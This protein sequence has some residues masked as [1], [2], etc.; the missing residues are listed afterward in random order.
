M[1][2]PPTTWTARGALTRAD[3]A[4][5]PHMMSAAPGRTPVSSWFGWEERSGSA[6]PMLIEG[7][8]MRAFSPAGCPLLA[9]AASEVDGVGIGL[10]AVAGEC[11]GVGGRC[12]GRPNVQRRS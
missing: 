8:S 6:P 3:E 11:E 2:Q 4:R 7:Y 10:G 9:E 12:A 5:A 1:T